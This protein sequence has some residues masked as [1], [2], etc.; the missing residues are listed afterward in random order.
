VKQCNGVEKRGAVKYYEAEQGFCS[1]KYRSAMAKCGTVR[2]GKG[3]AM[4]CGA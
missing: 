3:I 2:E 1:V 4:F